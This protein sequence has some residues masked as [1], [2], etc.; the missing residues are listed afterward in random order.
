MTIGLGL[1]FSPPRRL[2]LTLVHFQF[3]AVT[4]HHPRT[5]RETCLMTG[6]ALTQRAFRYLTVHSL[7]A[8]PGNSASSGSTSSVGV[9]PDPFAEGHPHDHLDYC[10]RNGHPRPIDCERS[11][12]GL[13]LG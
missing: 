2:T 6:I 5:V 12:Q 4:D 3:T 10:A 13:F 11:L 7:A 9:D 8:H 1:F